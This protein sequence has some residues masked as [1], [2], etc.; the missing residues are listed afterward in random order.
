M[1]MENTNYLNKN[2]LII[3]V[4]KRVINTFIFARRAIAKNRKVQVHHV[5]VIPALTTRNKS[6]IGTN[7]LM[8]AKVI[9]KNST[10]VVAKEAITDS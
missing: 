10:P 8:I 4:K 7:I 2:T 5:A 9:I 6:S 3:G 1:R